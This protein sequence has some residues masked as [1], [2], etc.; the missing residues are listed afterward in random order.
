MQ[1]GALAA[2]GNLCC[3]Q[4]LSA[5]VQREKAWLKKNDPQGLYTDNS[6]VPCVSGVDVVSLC[7][8]SM[9]TDTDTAAASTQYFFK[10]MRSGPKVLKV[11]GK[12]QR[13]TYLQVKRDQFVKNV[14]NMASWDR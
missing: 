11:M 14:Q 7:E 5:C 2:T 1:G 13:R 4:N 10:L 6:T 3:K 8:L 12:R 9:S